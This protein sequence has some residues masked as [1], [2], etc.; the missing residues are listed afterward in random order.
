M[1]VTAALFALAAVAAAAPKVEERDVSPASVTAALLQVL[2]SSIIAVAITNPGA[3]TTLI[4]QAFAT[5]TP[6]WFSQLPS[7]VQQYLITAEGSLVP[8]KAT[9]S[10]SDSAA[11][12]PMTTGASGNGTASSTG[13]YGNGT[14]TST[15]SSKT[16]TKTGSSSSATAGSSSS[17]AGASMPTSIIGGG[18]AGLAGLLAMLA[19]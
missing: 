3:A 12:P 13:K 4:E 14:V 11:A 17:S 15:G 9:G 1:K 5:G 10:A 8:A 7:D 18:I 6:S 2:P 19:L 16:A